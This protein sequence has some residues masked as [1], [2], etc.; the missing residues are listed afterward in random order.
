MRFDVRYRTLLTYDEL[1]VDS[2]NEVRARPA[3]TPYQSVI[4]Y[5]LRI[6]PPASI[7]NFVDGWGTEVDSFGV[8]LPHIAMEVIA[9]ATVETTR[10]PEVTALV[11][12]SGL[13]SPSFVD[14][15]VEYLLPTPATRAS[16]TIKDVADRLR[17][18]AQHV[19]GLATSIQAAVRDHLEYTPAVTSVSTT[20]AEAFELG[21]GVCQDYAHLTVAIARS[22]G[23]PARYVS[24]YFFSTSDADGAE[25]L[26][27]G[28]GADDL[29]TVQTHAWVEVAVPGHRWLAMDPTNGLIPGERHVKI[30]H[31]PDYDAVMPFRGTFIGP[32]TSEVTASVQI[33]RRAA[34]LDSGSP[35]FSTVSEQDIRLLHA[36]AA[37][38][39]Q[40]QQ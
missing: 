32:E 35:T 15:H 1:A 14:A 10:P 18:E 2:H 28:G 16:P 6:S 31:G 30:A 22:V 4:D 8:R 12:L 39:Q 36:E 5:E 23:L 17:S 27:E 20:A 21:A 3:T 37:A 34:D 13:D 33:R 25:H 29:V 9:E 24:G 26:A 11:S 7:R 38:Q 40:Q 19:L